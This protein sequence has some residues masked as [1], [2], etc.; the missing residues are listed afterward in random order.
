MLRREPQAR[1]KRRPATGDSSGSSSAAA[2]SM[3]ARRSGVSSPGVRTGGCFTEVDTTWG[4]FL[5]SMVR[6]CGKSESSEEEEDTED[7]GEDG[8]GVRAEEL[9]DPR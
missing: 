7:A 4:P 2:A 1:V 8:T 6:M 5:P 3:A 9:G